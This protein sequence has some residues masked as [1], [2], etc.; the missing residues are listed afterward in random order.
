MAPDKDGLA[1]FKI[2][3]GEVYAVKVANRADHDVAVNLAIDGLGMF[4]FSENRNYEVVIV[5]LGASRESFL[6]GISTTAGPTRFS[7]PSM[8]RS[9]WPSRRQPQRRSAPLA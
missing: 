9:P 2:N 7:S 4:A 5:P 1:F 3:R 8:P 6:A